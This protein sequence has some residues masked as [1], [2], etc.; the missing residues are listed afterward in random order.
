V[1]NA[2]WYVESVLDNDHFT[3][4]CPIEIFPRPWWEVAIVVTVPGTCT[5]GGGGSKGNVTV[6]AHDSG[7]LSG[8]RAYSWTIVAPVGTTHHCH[9][10]YDIDD[11]R[12]CG[13]IHVSVDRRCCSWGFSDRDIG[14]CDLEYIRG[15]RLLGVTMDITGKLYVIIKG[16]GGLPPFQGHFTYFTYIDYLGSTITLYSNNCTRFACQGDMAFWIYDGSLCS[17]LPNSGVGDV[18]FV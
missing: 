9:W 12:H 1:L 8:Q 17:P 11:I 14:I 15:H 4:I 13:W 10:D 7:A 3:F 2:D 6:Q 18:I 5:G 16:I